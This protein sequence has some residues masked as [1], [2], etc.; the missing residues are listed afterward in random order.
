[1]LLRISK[2]KLVSYSLKITIKWIEVENSKE[3]RFQQEDLK[4]GFDESSF[5]TKKWRVEDFIQSHSVGE[6]MT[7]SEVTAPSIGNKMGKVIRNRSKSSKSAIASF[8]F[9]NTS[10]LETSG[11]LSDDETLAYY[12]YFKSITRAGFR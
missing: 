4:K 2:V 12:I 1:M 5:K 9:K 6:L 10:S 8:N 3:A 7:A 11:Q